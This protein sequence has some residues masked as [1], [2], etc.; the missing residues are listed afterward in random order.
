MVNGR[1]KWLNVPY[2]SGLVFVR[3]Q[4]SESRAVHRCAYLPAGG[5]RGPLHYTRGVTARARSRD[6]GSARSLGRSGL[7]ELVTQLSHA[8]RFAQG[9][10]DAGYQVLNYVALNQFSCR[11]ATRYT[12]A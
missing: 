4:G 11:S 10:E 9:I 3:D 2:D 12:R 1:H 7:A 8:R 5:Q 6:L